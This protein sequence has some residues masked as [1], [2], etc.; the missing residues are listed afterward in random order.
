MNK[1]EINILT[2]ILANKKISIDI[3]EKS[4][5]VWLYDF[6]CVYWR[7]GISV[8]GND[9]FCEVKDIRYVFII[10]LYPNSKAID[11]IE[12]IKWDFEHNNFLYVDEF[13]VCLIHTSSFI[14]FM[15]QFQKIHPSIEIPSVFYPTIP[16]DKYDMKILQNQLG[17]WY[18]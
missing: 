10:A 9:V 4:Y 1:G 18:D 11:P 16:N 14:N 2:N 17:E 5:N 3:P 7:Y 13:N 6:K 15:E 8:F 12:H